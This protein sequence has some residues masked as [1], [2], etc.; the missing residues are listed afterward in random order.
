MKGKGK[1]STTPK[2]G[3]TTKSSAD[4]GIQSSEVNP[5]ISE[6]FIYHKDDITKERERLVLTHCMEKESQNMAKNKL[7]F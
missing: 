4:T 2:L 1:E 6:D 5:H 7:N 3:Y